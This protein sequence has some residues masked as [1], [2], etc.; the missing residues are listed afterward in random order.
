MSGFKWVIDY[1]LVVALVLS[2]GYNV[3]LMDQNQKKDLKIFIYENCILHSRGLQFQIEPQAEP[4][5]KVAGGWRGGRG[6]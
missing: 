6:V 3:F 5:G 2:V 1:L 4:Q